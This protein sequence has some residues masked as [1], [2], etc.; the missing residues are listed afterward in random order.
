MYEI[1]NTYTYPSKQEK[2]EMKKKI[3]NHDTTQDHVFSFIFRGCSA[4]TLP[5]VKFENF[6]VIG[7][8][9]HFIIIKLRPRPCFANRS[10]SLSLVLVSSY[11]LAT[12]KTI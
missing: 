11:S 1:L 10:I 5:L 6:R 4:T 12:P 8:H 9:E 7:E 2:K 3:A